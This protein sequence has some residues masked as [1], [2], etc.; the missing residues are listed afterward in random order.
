MSADRVRIDKW[1]WAARF[2]K[3][4]N[5][6][7]EAV[8]GGKVHLNDSR[9]KPSRALCIG[10]RLRIR[11]GE[12]EFS[13]EVTGLSERRGSASEAERLYVEDADSIAAREA[14][15]DER[16]LLHNAAPQPH[17]RPDKKARREWRRLTG[18]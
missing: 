17:G 12:L 1:L 16:R 8:S 18:K 15:R 6:A 4:R 11:K 7:T 2:F 14:R 9:I 13:V 3:T 5:L 10:D